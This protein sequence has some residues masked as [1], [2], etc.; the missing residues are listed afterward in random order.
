MTVNKRGGLVELSIVL[1]VGLLTSQAQ[2]GIVP[3]DFDNDCDVDAA[4]FQHFRTCALGPAVAQTNP[5]CADADLDADSDVDL[6]DFG[7]FQRCY[8]GEGQPADPN[9]NHT[10]VGTDCNCLCGQTNCSGTCT[11]TA[12]DNANCGACG[13]ACASGSTCSGGSCQPNCGPSCTAGLCG[14]ADGCG[15]ICGCGSGEH[16]DI[17]GRCAADG[18]GGGECTLPDNCTPDCANYPL[19]N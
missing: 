6:D 1:L 2:A 13:N 16:C 5:A 19:C 12:G 3:G 7:V 9:C 4:D 15:G 11:F 8:S 14:Y 17:T 18:G 10:C